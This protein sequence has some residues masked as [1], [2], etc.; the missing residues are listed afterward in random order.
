MILTIFKSLVHFDCTAQVKTL[1]SSEESRE[2]TCTSSKK[3]LTAVHHEK[4]K[5]AEWGIKGLKNISATT[6]HALRYKYA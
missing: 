4:K 5:E 1:R 2:I 3:L 6:A